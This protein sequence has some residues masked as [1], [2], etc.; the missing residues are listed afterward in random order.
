M[1]FVL[2]KNKEPLSPCHP[3]KARKLLKEGKAVIHKKYPFTIRLKE[4]KKTDKENRDEYRLKIDYGGRHTG[5]AILKNNKYVVW[6]AQ[7]EHRT[8]KK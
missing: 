8:D 6:L 3:A 1:V 2:N 5:L 4:L 7:I